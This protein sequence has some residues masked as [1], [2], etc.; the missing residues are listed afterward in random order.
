MTS[1]HLSFEVI[2]CNTI[3]TILTREKQKIATSKTDGQNVLNWLSKSRFASDGKE[4]Y[5]DMKVLWSSN[6]EHTLVLGTLSQKC[7]FVKK[8]SEIS[9]LKMQHLKDF[10]DRF[11]N[12]KV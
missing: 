6:S 4:I 11:C 8:K 12:C 1:I 3:T 5:L 2:I 9:A 10:N 7:I